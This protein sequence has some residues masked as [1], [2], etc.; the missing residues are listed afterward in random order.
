[1][2][3]C[4][5]LVIFFL[6]LSLH[7]QD[8]DKSKWFLLEG[9]SNPDYKVYMDPNIMKYEPG[10]IIEVRL[11]YDNTSKADTIN[12]VCFIKY[13]VDKDAYLM[14]YEEL[15]KSDSLKVL[16]TES[17]PKPLIPGS[18][19]SIIYQGVYIQ[20]VTMGPTRK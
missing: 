11:M 8:V 19:M 12:S 1:M 6:A 14:E 10:K 7:A 18:E 13:Y 4:L 5:S 3:V 16:R 20:A 17:V 9:V 2:K 15:L